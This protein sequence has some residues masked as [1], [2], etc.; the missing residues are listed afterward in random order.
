MKG[1]SSSDA[2][3]SAA[4]PLTHSSRSR[5]RRWRVKSNAPD[6]ASGTKAKANN[7]TL[8]SPVIKNAA[9]SHAARRQLRRRT[10]STS[11]SKT[12]GSHGEK[13]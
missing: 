1:T 11:A 2:S 9:P 10:K 3:P 6:A 12:S 5:Q 13:R 4:A 7:E 8:V